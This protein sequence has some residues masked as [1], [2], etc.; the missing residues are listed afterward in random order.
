MGRL[1][2]NGHSA[3]AGPD[4]TWARHFLSLARMRVVKPIVL[5]A[6]VVALAVYSFDCG[7]AMTPEQAM[8]C[9]DSMPC[10]SQGH[11][12]QDCCNTMV[13]LQASF[14]QPRPATRVSF[15]P[16]VIAAVQASIEFRGASFTEYAVA[17]YLD[18]APL[19][20]SPG[21]TPLRI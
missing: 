14:A 7:A 17:G 5:V 21:L 18:T 4:L 13:S 15:V 12:G 1:A 20:A 19:S 6:L 3:A 11:D 10:S 16:M 9:C 8:K 2:G